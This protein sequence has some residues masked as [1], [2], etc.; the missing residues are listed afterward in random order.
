MLGFCLNLNFNAMLFKLIF[1][2]KL[3]SLDLIYV[4]LLF[5]KR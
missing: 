1:K 2:E 4:Y 5:S 3:K